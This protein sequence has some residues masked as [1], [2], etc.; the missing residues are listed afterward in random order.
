LNRRRLYHFLIDKKYGVTF[1]NNY[2]YKQRIKVPESP[3]EEIR[4]RV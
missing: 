2:E 4:S 3:K 1:K